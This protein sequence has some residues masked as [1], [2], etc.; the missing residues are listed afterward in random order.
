[1]LK[2]ECKPYSW[3]VAKIKSEEPFTLVRYGDGELNAMF[4]VGRKKGGGRTKNGDGHTLRNKSFRHALRQSVLQPPN[5]SNYHCSLW[6]D[7]NCQPHE[8]LARDHLSRLAPD[9]TWYNA[10]A[11]HFA[12]IEGRNYP[13]FEA[14][15]G[16]KR[17]VVVIGPK[18]LRAIDRAG[19]FEYQ[20][21]VQVPSKNA[22]F[23]RERVIKEALS[24]PEPC[25]YSIHAG[26]PAPVFAWDLWRERGDTCTILD[27]GS[28]LDGYGHSR[29]GGKTG[30]GRLTRK[31][32]KRRATAAILR[33]NLTGE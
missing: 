15:R 11:I 17:P 9:V 26:P 1:M 29:F 23:S 3:W 8:R 10:L 20:G 18:H 22:F 6:M 24:Y 7:D 13:Y 21:F 16:Q 2:T 30:G 4:W 31:F 28:I 14:M 27:L 32:W 33:R 5:G 25:L 12:N 19:C